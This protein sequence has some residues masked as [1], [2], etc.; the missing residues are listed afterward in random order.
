MPVKDVARSKVVAVRPD[1]SIDRIIEELHDTGVGSVIVVEGEVPV[2][3]VTDRD[4]AL[5]GVGGEKTAVTAEDLMTPEV[6]TVEAEEGIFE[7]IRQMS[8]AGVRRVPLVDADE[9]LVGIVTMDDLLV[10]LTQELG[11]LGQVIEAES[12]PYPYEDPAR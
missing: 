6:F 10:L 5:Y 7:T 1:T 2:G 8:D 3:I 12:P 4:V 11:N 9:Q